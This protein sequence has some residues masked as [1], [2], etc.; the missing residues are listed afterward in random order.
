[1]VQSCYTTLIDE[2]DFKNMQKNA[3]P[4]VLCF[5]GKDHFTPT[6][7]SSESKFYTWKLNKE[8]GPI[9][10]VSLLVI[11]ELDKHKL[12]PAVLTAINQL[13]DT[14]C[15]TLPVIS[16]TSLSSHLKAVAVWNKAGPLHR[17]PVLQPGGEHI[18]SSH[19]QPAPDPASTSTQPSLPDT[20]QP[21]SEQPRVK[22]RPPKKYV[23]H[24]CGV[25][26]PR[27]PDLNG[28]L[29]KVHREGEPIICERPP[30][31]GQSFSS[32]ATLKKQVEG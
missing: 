28:H 13:E 29:W 9:V 26:K 1:M 4:I 10:S 30:C 6:K 8:L 5:N 17:G 23:C 11:E 2:P 3:Y 16:P 25:V 19:T 18:F 14:I 22:K 32:K 31:T 12:A 27:K 20:D 15:Q 24:H 7:P 21:E